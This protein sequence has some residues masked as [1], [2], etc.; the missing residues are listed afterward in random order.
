[1]AENSSSFISLAKSFWTGKAKEKVAKADAFLPPVT[2]Q[3]ELTPPTPWMDFEKLKEM[4]SD[5]ALENSIPKS[6][7]GMNPPIFGVQGVTGYMG[8]TGVT[9]WTGISG[10]TGSY[11]GSWGQFDQP[12]SM[13]Y[14]P[15]PLIE[16]PPPPPPKKPVELEPEEPPRRIIWKDADVSP[17]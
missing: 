14:T 4:Q 10:V 6:P 12:V 7:L 3:E 11:G 16:N 13:K 8:T 2:P 9:G 1:V 17:A 15:A 5:L